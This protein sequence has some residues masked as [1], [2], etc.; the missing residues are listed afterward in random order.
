M[1]NTAQDLNN[2]VLDLE[3]YVKKIVEIEVEKKFKEKLENIEKDLETEVSNFEPGTIS[4][5]FQVNNAKSEVNLT[6]NS[7]SLETNLNNKP[8][9][10]NNNFFKESNP[11]EGI[12]NFENPVVQNNIDSENS[13]SNFEI[14][15]N[16][17]DNNLDNVNDGSIS[18]DKNQNDSNINDNV[19]IPQ[20][21]TFES[22]FNQNS[23]KI[24][25]KAESD[26][27]IKQDSVPKSPATSN[28]GFGQEMS[29]GDAY[30]KATDNQTM[31]SFNQPSQSQENNVVEKVNFNEPSTPENPQIATSFGKADD[32][33]NNVINKNWKN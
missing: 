30:E 7:Q 31:N 10:S 6:E 14:N 3:N 21:A 29:L 8:V 5:D 13:Q 2:I 32:L 1:S 22:N 4:N 26:N 11:S 15:N 17:V 12:M 23:E 19:E 25:S 20:P 24:Q 9:Q 33:L 18:F 27:Q 16:V 28:I